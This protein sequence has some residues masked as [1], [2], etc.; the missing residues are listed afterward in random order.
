MTIVQTYF[1]VSK[2]VPNETVSAFPVS[3]SFFSR[4]DFDLSDKI[5]V[6]ER[7]FIPI[8]MLGMC[9]MLTIFGGIYPW[10]DYYITYHNFEVGVKST[11]IIIYMHRACLLLKGL[12]IQK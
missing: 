5:C 6:L 9:T 11:H 4:A 12:K 8:A 7:L 1:F 10:V 3:A 2:N